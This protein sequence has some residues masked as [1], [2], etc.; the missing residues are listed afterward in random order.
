MNWRVG[1]RIAFAT[2]GLGVAATVFVLSRNR[3]GQP[4]PPPD[5]A[6]L[7]GDENLVGGPGR[8]SSLKGGQPS[9]ELTFTGSSA[10]DDGRT[11]FQNA[12]VKGLGERAFT[13][14]GGL[15]ETRG[16]LTKGQSP[17]QLELTGGFTFEGS[18]G[19][20][21]GGDRGTYDDATG[22][23]TI[24]GAVTF[25][26]GRLSGE[27]TGAVYNRDLD[28]VTF[29]EGAKAHVAPDAKGLGAAEATAKRML[30][31]RGQHTL[32]MEEDS[33]IAGDTQ[34]LTSKNAT[35]VFTDDESAIKH[36]ELREGANVTAGPKAGAGQP[37]MS[38]DD[39]TMSF[40]P[41]GVTM[42]H[43]TLTGKAVMTTTDAGRARSIRASR[44][45]FFT[46]KDGRTLTS[47][48]AQD[49]VSV[50]IPATVTTAGRTITAATL[51]AKGNEKRGLTEARF[52]GNPRFEETPLPAPAGAAR[53]RGP[54]PS[55]ARKRVG[56]ATTLILTLGGQL[57]AIQT[58]VFQQNATFQDDRVT[59]SADVATYDDA[60]QTLG[61]A[62]SSR[63]SRRLSNVKTAEM[64]VDGRAIDLGLQTED[65]HARGDIVTRS[66]PKASAKGTSQASL[67]EPEKLV[68]GQATELQYVKESGKATYTGAP[69]APARLRQDATEIS[70]DR[71]EYTENTNHLTA[72]GNVDSTI[73]MMAPAEGG[74][75]PALQR[76]RVLAETLVY[77][78]AQRTAVYKGPKVTLTMVDNTRIESSA[79]TFELAKESRDLKRMR[80]EGPNRGVF[81]TLSG[82]YEVLGDLLTYDAEA[83]VYTLTGK[84]ALV[85]SQDKDAAGQ[86]PGVRCKLTTS[87]TIVLDRKTGSIQTRGTALTQGE[88]KEIDCSV[89]IRPVK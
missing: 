50:E 45:D 22:V 65:L 1:A 51:Q 27:S 38:A 64:T 67:F 43:A 47:L 16:S 59:A 20:V 78:D 77:D 73:E 60:K 70:A 9:L 89:S 6:T 25:K 10:Y 3:P 85:K 63:D 2:L 8:L 55:V 34:V 46:G 88:A 87:P 28:T 44:I 7:K 58:A 53:G 35:V 24:P 31:A 23:M 40:Y 56:T 14:R 37:V 66:T 49:G 52:E 62:Q 80:A 69:K 30:L 71:I 54:A 83:S 19:M 33:R 26:R 13:L 81:G 18:D 75:P 4:A 17:A 72:R 36:L 15:I 74:K 79:V 42:Q 86:P 48:N 21:V 11:R 82:G 61:L 41:D 29:L 5:S 57:D 32:R 39:I 68:L 84:N 76:Y 12:V